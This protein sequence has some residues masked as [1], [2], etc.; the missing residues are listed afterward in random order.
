MSFE[1][2]KERYIKN[3]ITDAQL[4]RF[5]DLGVITETQYTELH[6][7]KH[8]AETETAADARRTCF[9]GLSTIKVHSASGGLRQSDSNSNGARCM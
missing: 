3:Y 5:K 2:I 7:M 6:E 9:S 1:R 4:V 8:P